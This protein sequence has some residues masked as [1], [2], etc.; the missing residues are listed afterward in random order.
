MEDQSFAESARLAG[1][2]K[3][4]TRASAAIRTRMHDNRIRERTGLHP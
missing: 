2:V 3:G 1:I 4:E